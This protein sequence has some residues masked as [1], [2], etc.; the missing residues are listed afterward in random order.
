M[1]RKF[2]TKI[3]RFRSEKLS[4]GSD[5]AMVC[6][7]LLQF[8][9]QKAFIVYSNAI[10][11]SAPNPSLFSFIDLTFYGI[12]LCFDFT[13]FRAETCTMSKEL[14]EPST[15]VIFDETI[16]RNPKQ[17]LNYC[18]K[19][20]LTQERYVHNEHSAIYEYIISVKG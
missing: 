5:I 18:K 15:F 12:N 19:S 14:S 7:E 13:R 8:R 1:H 20:A 11:R 9:E 3:E 4:N 6:V 10:L 16:Y 17:L 2:I